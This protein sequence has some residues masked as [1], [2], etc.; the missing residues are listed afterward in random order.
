MGVDSI[1]EF[2][3]LRLSMK[4]VRKKLDENSQLR[5]EKGFQK[6]ALV[7]IHGAELSRLRKRNQALFEKD[8]NAEETA[9]PYYRRLTTKVERDFADQEQ[10]MRPL[11]PFLIEIN[12]QAND[13]SKSE[14]ASLREND[15]VVETTVGKKLDQLESVVLELHARK[16]LDSDKPG[17]GEV[18]YE[19]KDA[20][21]KIIWHPERLG[22]MEYMNVQITKGDIAW[23]I[24]SKGDNVF[25]V[26][27]GSTEFWLQPR[28]STIYQRDVFEWTRTELMGGGQ[29]D[30]IVVDPPWD[31]GKRDPVRGPA[32]KF[33]TM[34]IEALDDLPLKQLLGRGIIVLW[35]IN[36]VLE[37]VANWAHRSGLRI[38]G[39]ITWVKVSDRGNV[40]NST[41]YYTQ[42]CK[43]IAL[44]LTHQEMSDEEMTV[45]GGDKVLIAQRN[46]QS[47]KP[48]AL[49]RYLEGLRF[50]RKLELFGRFYNLRNGWTTVGN[51][52][53][54]NRLRRFAV[55]S[56]SAKRGV[57]LG[58][59]E[60]TVENMLKKYKKDVQEC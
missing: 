49:I 44:V 60:S 7:K 20:K 40:I 38:V 35:V 12:L 41:G 55:E 3:G 15:G 54:P 27:D 32:I 39:S 45:L 56:H 48:L 37:D 50:M 21:A 28:E 51:E 10:G 8:F 53:Y 46:E 19:T 25:R 22:T 36:R 6:S 2:S 42:H 13:I 9:I 11:S 18:E 16:L 58:A 47:Q 34:G 24:R 43:E 30:C 26:A 1:E 57:V 17:V 29:Y 4:D 5:G 52:V 23:K 31:A 14:Y 33:D 59:G